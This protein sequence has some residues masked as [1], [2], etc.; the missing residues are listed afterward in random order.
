MDN[1]LRWFAICTSMLAGTFASEFLSHRQE[2]PV[3]S[4]PIQ[5]AAPHQTEMPTKVAFRPVAIDRADEL[6]N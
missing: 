3:K 6:N 5:A 2:L 4:A 1:L